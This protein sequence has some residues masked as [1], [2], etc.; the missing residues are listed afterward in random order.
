MLGLLLLCEELQ[1]SSIPTWNTQQFA[2]LND[3]SAQIRFLKKW[4]E[5]VENSNWVQL[6]AH[7]FEN[8]SPR[9]FFTM[10]CVPLPVRP[11]E[12]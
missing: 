5:N 3:A 1:K 7:P 12:K 4:M 9:E 8:T 10:G 6:G 2:S 11:I